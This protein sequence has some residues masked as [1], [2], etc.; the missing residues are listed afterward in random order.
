MERERLLR[1]AE[2][3]RRGDR[4]LAWL[5]VAQVAFAFLAALF[6]VNVT[7]LLI[8]L[9]FGW[10]SVFRAPW[11]ILLAI[12]AAFLAILFFEHHRGHA[13][14]FE[15]VGRGDLDAAGDVYAAVSLMAGSVPLGA[16]KA[17]AAAYLF[18]GLPRLFW[19]TVERFRKSR[20]PDP[21]A[22]ESAVALAGRLLE[23]PNGRVE[24]GDVM[25]T[26]GEADLRHGLRAL[27]QDL[28]WAYVAEGPKGP[29]L[30]A[31]DRLKGL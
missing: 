16:P 1:A 23:R 30:V 8:A 29:R 17:S 26:G 28:R 19:A 2:S 4:A 3:T 10:W 12:D 20:R 27:V 21:P 9:P 18:F 22:L 14:R 11:G 7:V 6:F 5:G 15:D 24:I 13:V 31:T 25:C